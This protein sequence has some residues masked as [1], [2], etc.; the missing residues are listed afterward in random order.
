MIFRLGMA[1][2]VAATT[3]AGLSAG[4]AA[5]APACADFHWIG[6]AGSG[7]RDGAALAADGGMGDVVYQSY[8]QLATELA[9]GGQTMTAEAVVYPAARVPADGDLLGWGAFMSSVDAGVEALGNQYAAFTQ[10]C[11]AS[12]VV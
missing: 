1:V 7:Q 8:Q 3:L 6:A 11:P 2:A 10:Q 12:E 4:T 5:A 9:A